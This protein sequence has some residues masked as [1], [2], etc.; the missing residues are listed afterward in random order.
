MHKNEITVV[1]GE[2]PRAMV[3]T[4][5]TALKPEQALRP[6]ATIG[7]KPNLVLDKPAASG[8]TTHPEIVEGVI[9]YFQ[10]KGYSNLIIME[11]SWVGARTEEAFRG[12]RLPGIS[13]P[14]WCGTARSEKR[15][16]RPERDGGRYFDGLCRAA[17][18]W[19]I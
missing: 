18:S 9:R 11:S 4:L 16:H 10:A 13:G 8:A 14:V 2:N 12:L 6:G 1:Y 17:G 19:T 15:P 3:E 5:L 7:L